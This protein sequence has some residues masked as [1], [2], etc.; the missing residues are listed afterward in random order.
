MFCSEIVNRE[1]RSVAWPS[2]ND[3]LPRPMT[4]S[5][6]QAQRWRDLARGAK[7]RRADHSRRHRS[8]RQAAR[9]DKRSSCPTARSSP[10]SCQSESNHAACRPCTQ[11]RTR[12]DDWHRFPASI[13]PR[14][15]WGSGKEFPGQKVPVCVCTIEDGRQPWNTRA[16]ARV[17]ALRRT[18][19]T[20]VLVSRAA[21]RPN[22]TL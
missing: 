1:G 15:V 6:A 9:T 12:S 18:G 14:S 5:R 3:M 10:S 17:G 11:K 19:R 20:G 16:A 7:D 8:R 2:C 22:A 21:L 13:P 4:C